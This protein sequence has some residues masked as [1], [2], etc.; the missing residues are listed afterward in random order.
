MNCIAF[1]RLCSLIV[2]FSS[3][4]KWSDRTCGGSE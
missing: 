4:S 1:N 2:I 3:F